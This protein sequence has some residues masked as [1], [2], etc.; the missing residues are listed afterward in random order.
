MAAGKER[1]WA[2]R[3]DG[4][5]KEG[6]QWQGETVA[7]KERPQW[8]KERWRR[9]RRDGGG[10]GEMAAGKERQQWGKERR[11]GWGV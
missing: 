7:G 4:G 2:A 6:Q 11:Q 10:Q 3:R 5:G 9:A 1:W 8:G